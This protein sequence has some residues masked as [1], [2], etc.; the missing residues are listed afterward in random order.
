MA[1]HIALRRCVACRTARPK[2]EL[3]RVVRTANGEMG[4]DPTGKAPGRGAY[5]CR[6]A[7]CVEAALRK[8]GLRRALGPPV[9]AQVAEQMRQAVGAASGDRAQD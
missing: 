1:R 7:E 9:P 4:V 2:A 6:R 3:M 8:Q 5:V